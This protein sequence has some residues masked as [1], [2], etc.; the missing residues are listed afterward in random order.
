MLVNFMQYVQYR[1]GAEEGDIFGEYGFLFLL[2][3]LA[4]ITGVALLGTNLGKFFTTM[5]GHF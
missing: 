5:A 2:I 4:A 1:F 3:A